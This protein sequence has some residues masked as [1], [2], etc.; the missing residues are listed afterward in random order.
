MFIA[1]L[2]VVALIFGLGAYIAETL[3]GNRKKL[4]PVPVRVNS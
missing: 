3:F 4:Q 1:I 2:I